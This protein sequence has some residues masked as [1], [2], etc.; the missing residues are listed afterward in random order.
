MTD[1]ASFAESY[2]I[3]EQT[4]EA[5]QEMTEADIDQLVPLVERGLAAHRVCEER[6]KQVRAMLEEKLG[7]QPG[8]GE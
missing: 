2:A 5:L 7:M 4:A 8:T 6:I 3:L 1:T